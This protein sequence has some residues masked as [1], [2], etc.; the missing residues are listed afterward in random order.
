MNEMDDKNVAIIAPDDGV[1][2]A[3]AEPTPRADEFDLF[4]KKHLPPLPDLET[5]DELIYTWDIKDWRA[6]NKREHSPAFFCGGH[7]WRILLFPFGNNV[8]FASFYLEQGYDESEIPQDW[9]C[10]AQF[11]LVL[12]NPNDPTMNV[13]HTA[14][15]RF[16]AEEAD[17]GF[18]R[19]VEL[20]RLLV[21]FEPQGKPL[22]E[23]NCAKV[24]A[25]VRV[26]KDPTGVLW[27]NFVLY[28]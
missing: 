2:P 4:M 26:V 17:W 13:I 19:F 24:T 3:D 20:R 9:R 14:N 25:Y 28:G 5:E 8:E 16:T 22:L 27:H 23:D 6:L 10:C 21:S 15:H 7:P 1:D 11:A 18:T 12:W